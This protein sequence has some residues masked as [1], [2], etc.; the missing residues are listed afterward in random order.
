MSRTEHLIENALIAVESHKTLN[1]FINEEIDRGNVGKEPI[2]LTPEQILEHIY[3]MA[4]Y[5]KYTWNN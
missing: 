2:T 1:E 4:I 5:V 3:E